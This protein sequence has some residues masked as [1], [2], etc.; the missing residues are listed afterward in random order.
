LVLKRGEEQDELIVNGI[1]YMMFKQKSFGPLKK[2]PPYDIV[3]SLVE[4]SREVK[5]WRT[6]GIAVGIAFISLA[7]TMLNFQSNLYR[8]NRTFSQQLVDLREQV[9]AH[10]KKLTN[11]PGAGGASIPAVGAPEPASH[12]EIRRFKRRF[13][14]CCDWCSFSICP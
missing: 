10:D 7:L 2:L 6:I 12:S 3:S 4:L 13:A 1:R 8:D 5:T 9:A 14:K 11:L